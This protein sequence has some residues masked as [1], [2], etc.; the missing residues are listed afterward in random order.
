MSYWYLNKTNP[1]TGEVLQT[2]AFHEY[3][4]LDVLRYHVSETVVRFLHLH[5][6]YASPVSPVVWRIEQKRAT[7]PMNVSGGKIGNESVNGVMDMSAKEFTEV[8]EAVAGQELRRAEPTQEQLLEINER[9]KKLRSVSDKRTLVQLAYNGYKNSGVWLNFLELLSEITYKPGWYIRT[10]IEGD[11]MWFQIGVTEEAE[12]SW[13]VVAKKKV[14][15]RGAKHYLS[16]HMCRNEVVSMA[17]HAIHRAEVH[18]VNEWFRYKG[19]S[20]FNPHLDP[21][22]LV[23]VARYKK[24][25][26]VRENAMNMEEPD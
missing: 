19:A 10:G 2:V 17:Y 26:N 6:V 9:I 8:A 21:D 24:N 7:S 20:I 11:R 5:G 13:D 14:P 22:A 15:W 23:E 18:E 12:I 4:S 25:F 1:K 16:P 3:P